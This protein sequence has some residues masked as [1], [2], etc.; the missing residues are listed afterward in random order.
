MFITLEGTEG[1]GKS[2]LIRNLQ[3]YFE[4]RGREVV[5]CRE[6]GGTPLAEDIRGLLLDPEISEKVNENTELMLM[7]A[8]RMQNININILPALN[9]FKIVLCDRFFDSSV[10]YQS[11]GRGINREKL[12][13]LNKHFVNIIPDITFWLDAPI[14]VGMERANNRGK[15]D[16]FEKEKLE[17]F[18]KVR[19]GYE[20]L[21]QEEPG[22][23]KRLDAT[24][25]TDLVFQTAIA[26][27]ENLSF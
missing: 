24:Q 15:L 18:K 26:Y 6:P 8:S 14:E 11:F 16:R 1:V 23:I 13:I 25:S 4:E 27:L 7:Y 3:A 22:R 10:C 19:H 17:F 21:H 12:D 9:D 5:L 20:V 2:T